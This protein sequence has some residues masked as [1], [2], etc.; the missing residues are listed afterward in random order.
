MD[1]SNSLDYSISENDNTTSHPLMREAI[2]LALDGALPKNDSET[3]AGYQAA[4]SSI[5]T[6]FPEHLER[7]RHQIRAGHVSATERF[8]TKNRLLDVLKIA[9]LLADAIPDDDSWPGI[10]FVGCRGTK[11]L[12]HHRWVERMLNRGGIVISSD[13]TAAIP[14]ISRGLQLSTG[15]NGRRARLQ[16]AS[17]HT[18]PVCDSSAWNRFV[19]DLR[20]AVW[21]APGHLPLLAP[22]ADS[23]RIIARDALTDEPLVVVAQVAGGQVVHSVPHWWQYAEPD[24]TEIGRK[25]LASVPS[26]AD[27]GAA[28]VNAK[29]GMYGAG[30][31]MLA[32][33]LL[34]IDVALDSMT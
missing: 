19:F 7:F 29:L 2:A 16:L 20:P 26:F 14:V 3:L 15:K 11:D 12:D 33:L 4:M 23:T 30:S 28:H 22:Q 27:V 18:P 32:S 13:K 21:L 9:P 1:Y 24:S 17:E 31:V 25:S 34:G 8:R 10:V 5:S 6:G